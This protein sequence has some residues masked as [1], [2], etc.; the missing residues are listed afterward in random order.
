MKTIFIVIIILY[1]SAGFCVDSPPVIGELTYNVNTILGKTFGGSV[2]MGKLYNFENSSKMFTGNFQ[3]HANKEYFATG[4]FWRMH[5]FSHKDGIGFFYM[6]TGGVDYAK[7][8]RYPLVLSPGGSSPDDFEPIKFKGTYLHATIGGGISFFIFR[9]IRTLWF[10][11]I[12]FKK[13]IASL[14]VSVGF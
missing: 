7:G 1:L 11:D 13:S 2:G 8:I 6:L 10:V 4:L 9:D 12:G 5:S 14:N 3:Y